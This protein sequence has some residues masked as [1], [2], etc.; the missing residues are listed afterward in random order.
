MAAS[1][2]PG[3]AGRQARGVAAAAT[4][5]AVSRPPGSLERMFG[6]NVACVWCPL[7]CLVVWLVVVCWL[8]FGVL[9]CVDD[10]PPLSGWDVFKDGRAVG[11]CCL[12]GGAARGRGF[13]CC[14]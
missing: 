9:A 2:A 11:G 14:C 4:G 12:R 3:S 13:C 6:W 8:P 7:P 1:A 5:N 10:Q